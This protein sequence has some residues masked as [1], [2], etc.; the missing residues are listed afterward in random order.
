ML[1]DKNLD[2][3]YLSTPIALHAEQANKV[4]LAG[5]HLWC[6]KPFTSNISHSKS[7]VALSRKKI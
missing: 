1:N 3:I 6:E 4:L 7:L 5:K 2:I